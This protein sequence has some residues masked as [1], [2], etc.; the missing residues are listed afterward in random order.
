MNII[1]FF[2]YFFCSLFPLLSMCCVPLFMPISCYYQNGAC[3]IAVGALVV[4]S[5]CSI[6]K[7]FHSILK[8]SITQEIVCNGLARRKCRKCQSV[9]FSWQPHT[10]RNGDKWEEGNWDADTQIVLIVNTL[11]E[12]T[13]ARFNGKKQQQQQSVFLIIRHLH[14]IFHWIDCAM[15]WT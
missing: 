4:C 12:N 6:A 13:L 11:K 14:I 2:S 9:S 5:V 1:T 7:P 3:A 8:R 10:N 15:N